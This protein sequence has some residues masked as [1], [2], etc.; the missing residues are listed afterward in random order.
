MKDRLQ[1]LLL[2]AQNMWNQLEKEQRIKLV[3]ASVVLIATV[4][5][6]IYFITRPSM[7]IILNGEDAIVI[8]DAQAILNDAGIQS[9]IENNGRALAVDE[10]EVINARVVL[11]GSPVAKEEGITFTDAVDLIKVGTSEKVTNEAL[12][13]ANTSGLEKSLEAFDGVKSADVKLS[14]PEQT[15][16]FLDNGEEVQASVKLDTTKTLTEE[17]VSGIA[18]F[19][20]NAV[21][22]LDSDNVIIVDQEGNTLYSGGT[23]DMVSANSNYEMEKLI[24]EEAEMEIQDMIGP[25]Y[26]DVKITANLVVDWNETFIEEVDYDSAL[27]DGINTGI[28]VQETGSSTSMTGNTMTGEPGINGNDEVAPNYVTGNG[29]E[30]SSKSDDFQKDYLV[31]QTVTNTNKTP[32]S[33]DYEQSSA[34]VIVYDYNYF[35]EDRVKKSGALDGVTWEEYKETIPSEPMEVP[36]DIQSAIADS[37]G[38]SQVTVTGY[39]VPMFIDEVQM[40]L[41]LSDYAMFIILGILFILLVVL[42]L[43]NTSVE[44]IEDVEPEI[45]VKDLL[46]SSQEEEE[47][48]RESVAD[49]KLKQESEVK[50]QLDKFITEQPEVVASLLRN[51][52]NDEWE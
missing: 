20:S 34:G 22:G 25:L 9:E 44:E 26:D 6:T 16:Y 10:E 2:S 21:V 3:I 37:L 8:G 28:V 41:N 18:N 31:D 45:S 42:I 50:E 32:G 11:A 51:W 47:I 27:G 15:N 23:T 13:L 36:A 33:I 1:G 30:T 35:Y 40:P 14:T 17:Q 39:K 48:E 12:E 29:N 24:K 38:V 52:L 4:V 49:I 7:V 46:A 19:V 5:T 43:R